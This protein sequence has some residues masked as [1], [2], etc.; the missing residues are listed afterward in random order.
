MTEQPQGE[1]M[2]WEERGKQRQS[3]RETEG[4]TDG[5]RERERRGGWACESNRLS[6]FAVY[7]LSKSCRKRDISFLS[8]QDNRLVTQS[9]LPRRMLGHPGNPEIIFPAVS[10]NMW[11][12]D[13]GMTRYKNSGRG[14]DAQELVWRWCQLASGCKTS[15]QLSITHNAG[16]TDLPH[17]CEVFLSGKRGT[18]D[19][20]SQW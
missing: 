4:A 8:I 20:E 5:E 3:R 11:S 10:P 7:F 16:R 2:T 19:Q 12:C 17:T 1:R 6:L 9:H 18:L 14:M 15:S 13:F